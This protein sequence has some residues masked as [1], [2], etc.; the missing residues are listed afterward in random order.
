MTAKFFK[1]EQRSCD[2]SE[3]IPNSLYFTYDINL[4]HDPVRAKDIAL[5]SNVKHTIQSIPNASVS[6][7]TDNDCLKLISELP[8]ELRNALT[9]VFKGTTRGMIRADIC[10]GVALYLTGGWY[11]DVDVETTC[12]FRKLATRMGDK[13]IL[14]VIPAWQPKMAYF[15]AIIAVT[16]PQD[17]TIRKYLWMFVNHVP[18]T[19]DENTGTILLRRAVE[20]TGTRVYELRESRGPLILHGNA[21]RFTKKGYWCDNVV[22][23]EAYDDLWFYSRIIGSRMCK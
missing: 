1:Y 15:Q 10:R 8:R 21:T 2:D 20:E 19:P 5:A 3:M 6:F 11:L 13:T 4:L 12:D 17:P 7:L 9:L 14:T 16:R 23:D 22:Y 18:Q